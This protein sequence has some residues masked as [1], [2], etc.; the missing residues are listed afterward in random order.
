MSVITVDG[1][2][3]RAKAQTEKFVR[4]CEQRYKKEIIRTA[5]LL[6]QKKGRS[7]LMI[8]GP[9]SSG[10]TTTAKL[11]K[12]ELEALSRR[13]IIISLD[14]FYSEN[15]LE[16]YFED[17]TVD[18]ERIE[19]LDTA[20]IYECLERLMKRG[21]CLLPHFSFMTK[22]RDGYKEI[23]VGK[24]DVIIVEG[25]HALNPLITGPLESEQMLRLYVSVSSRVYD[26]EDVFLTK[27]DIRFIRRLIRDYN[28]RNSKPDYTF[29]LWNGVRMGEDR[30]LFPFSDLADIKIDTLHPYEFCVFRDVAIELL[31]SIDRESKYYDTASLLREKLQHFVS[32]DCSV[33]PENSLLK[34]FI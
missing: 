9:S 18:Y 1:I 27:R 16:Y 19:T 31:S 25:L 3:G 13:A 15:N 22:K 29:Y 17:G 23:T 2:N 24:D 20:Y 14:D 7:L 5:E 30:Y 32:L 11:I 34:E 33:I 12:A 28:F 10:K 21:C 6:S 4:E 8:A 26:G